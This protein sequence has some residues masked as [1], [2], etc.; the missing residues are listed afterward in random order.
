MSAKVANGLLR[1]FVSSEYVETIPKVLF[2][3]ATTV[4]VGKKENPGD[5]KRRKRIFYII[6]FL[7]FFKYTKD[8]NLA[9]LYYNRNTPWRLQVLQCPTT[10]G[11]GGWCCGTCNHGFFMRPKTQFIPR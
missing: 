4:K 1:L 5:S 10:V 9:K 2:K 3:G 6:S 11:H 7:I 8:L